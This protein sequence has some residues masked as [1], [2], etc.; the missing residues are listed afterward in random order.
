MEKRR[1]IMQY[2]DDFERNL[3]MGEYDPLVRSMAEKGKVQWDPKDTAGYEIEDLMQEAYLKFVE[4]LDAEKFDRNAERGA[5]MKTYMYSC[6]KNRLIDIERARQKKKYSA[7]TFVADIYKEVESNQ[8][9]LN[10][11]MQPSDFDRV[12]TDISLQDICVKLEKSIRSTDLFAKRGDYPTAEQLFR[13]LSG[14][15]EGKIFKQIAAEE[16]MSCFQLKKIRNA[17]LDAL[18]KENLKENLRSII[19]ETA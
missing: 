10:S 6:A 8:I 4:L 15:S 5:S 3:M 12:I 13:I 9:K 7:V 19:T 17:A 2:T 1:G 11:I 18:E 16:G 14:I